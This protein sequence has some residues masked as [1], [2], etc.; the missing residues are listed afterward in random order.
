MRSLV[1]VGV[2][3]VEEGI[4]EHQHI[5][6]TINYIEDLLAELIDEICIMRIL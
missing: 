5:F 2:P 3:L 6:L 4:L 1:V